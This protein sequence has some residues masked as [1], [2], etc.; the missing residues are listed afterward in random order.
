MLNAT[1]SICLR[2]VLLKLNLIDVEAAVG[3]L[4]KSGLVM[5]E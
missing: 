5:V 1:P 2:I 3:N 4:V